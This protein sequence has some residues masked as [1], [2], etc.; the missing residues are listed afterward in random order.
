METPR[1]WSSGFASTGPRAK[2]SLDIHGIRT[3]HTS[4][5]TWRTGQSRSPALRWGRHG[6]GSLLNEIRGVGR[7]CGV[8]LWQYHGKLDE[9][10]RCLS[11]DGDTYMKGRT[12]NTVELKLQNFPHY[13]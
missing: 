8:W 9:G 2:L 10:Q 7:Y 5:D 13:P 11:N 4:E 6:F 12:R 3:D 1:G